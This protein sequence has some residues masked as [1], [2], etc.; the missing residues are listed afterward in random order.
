MCDASLR[1]LQEKYSKEN[2][3]F[4]GET[5]DIFVA[6]VH[7]NHWGKTV[8]LLLLLIIII[9]NTDTDPSYPQ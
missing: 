1:K 2:V 7:A 3:H 6:V 5:V 8:H 9:I 4:V